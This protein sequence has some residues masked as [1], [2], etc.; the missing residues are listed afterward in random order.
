MPPPE[1]PTQYAQ[2][3]AF[4]LRQTVGFGGVFVAVVAVQAQG[5]VGTL[6]EAVDAQAAVVQ[7]GVELAFDDVFQATVDGQGAAAWQ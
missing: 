6:A 3:L 5:A 4:E 2:L 7:Q 1:H